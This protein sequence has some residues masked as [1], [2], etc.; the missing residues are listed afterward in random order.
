MKLDLKAIQQKKVN[1]HP[2]VMLTAYD[3]QTAHLLEEAGI[4]L[5]LV[6]DTLGMV[7]QGRRT[8]RAVTLTHMLYHIEVVRNGAPDTFIVG[9]LPFATYDNPSSAV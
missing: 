1:H 4:D 2:I 7:F 3:A 8:T 9:D 5:L 6:G